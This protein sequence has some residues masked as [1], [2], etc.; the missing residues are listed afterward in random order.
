MATTTSAAD[1]VSPN[2]CRSASPL[3]YLWQASYIVVSAASSSNGLENVSKGRPVLNTFPSGSCF[4]W[5][6][7]APPVGLLTIVTLFSATMRVCCAG[8]VLVTFKSRLSVPPYRIENQCEDVKVFFAQTSVAQLH[9]RKFWNTLD[10]M[11]GG[12]AMPYA[13]DE[14]TQEHKLTVQVCS[15]TLVQLWCKAGICGYTVTVM[16]ILTACCTDIGKLAA[17]ICPVSMQLPRQ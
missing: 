4:I 13:W 6:E 7:A 1:H 15:A 14:P 5:S 11:S 12:N 9:E 16:A 10:P 2:S 8:S 3:P 17:P